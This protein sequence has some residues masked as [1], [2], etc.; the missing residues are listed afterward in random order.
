MNF[1]KLSV[2]KNSVAL[3]C[4]YFP[5]R[6]QAFIW[7][8]W[9]IVSAQRL[10]KIL[11]T[12]EEN[13]LTAAAEMGLNVPPSINEAWLIHGYLTVIRNNWHL[14][15][16]RQLLQLLDWDEV[17]L[18]YTLKEE[19]FL[20][21]KMG[22]DK[23][24]CPPL[25]FKNLSKE[26]KEKTAELKRI[27]L[28][29]F[30]EHSRDYVE[31]PFNFLLNYKTETITVK[32]EQF[33]FNIIHPFS[34]SHGDIFLNSQLDILPDNL[35][36]QYASLGIKGIWLPAILYTLHPIKGAEE[37][38]DGYEI[39][40]KTLADLVKKCAKHGLELYLYLNE[41]RCMPDTFYNKFP[42]WKGVTLDR[43]SATAN[44]TSRNK[45][46]IKWL[47]DACKNIFA[48]TPGLAGAFMITMSEN[49]T[50]CHSKFTGNNCPYCRDRPIPEIITEI[51]CAIKNG[52]H[53]SSPSAKVIVWDWAWMNSPEE[54][55]NID[56]E[57][58]I[59]EKLP[60]DI[61]LMHVSERGLKK[62]ISGVEITVDD[63]SI[64]QV[65]P[66]EKSNILWQHAKKLGMKTVAKVQLNNS[67]ELAAV[68]YIPVP[69]LIREHLEKIS[70][71]KNIDG[72]ILSWT[73]GG[74][75]GGNLE[76]LNQTPEQIALIKFGKKAAP[77]VC[78]AWKIFSE[79]FRNFP[80]DVLLMYLGPVNFGP[81]NILHLE[82]TEHKATM[83]GFPYDD[84]KAW[85]ARFSEDILEEQFRKLSTRWG[86]GLEFLSCAAKYVPKDQIKNII[87][88][89]NISLAAYCHFRSTY[90]QIKFI[91]LR[92]RD[93]IKQKL[94]EVVKEE[95]ELAV[96]LH[97]V[98]RNDSR[99]G[100]EA[101]NHYF[102]SLNDLR[103]K[104][105][106]CEYIL[107]HIN[108]KQR[109]DCVK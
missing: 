86:E 9:E 57:L 90:L 103:E 2:D 67:W 104:V 13:V 56:F 3:D 40:L 52:I 98:M 58:E 54:G 23:P 36:E 72:L 55:D 31:K 91:R 78:E 73:H 53:A 14:L 79:A 44:C 95:L 74:Y 20:W 10:A 7:K 43:I 102:Y 33:K 59:I 85:R 100:F 107:N 15:N 24:V 5:T 81:M 93:L 19:D 47:E 68:P 32:E 99:I 34:A 48:K 96:K 16:Y 70:S 25:K 76:L 38:S 88:Q 50:H 8:N 101:S 42:D 62:H 80:F 41:P 26:E 75:P 11:G 35:L 21:E 17:K 71:M 60:R 46:V 77:I 64:S 92:D 18:A 37:F 69:Y 84:L 22:A 6:Q 89:K 12:T 61:Y 97:D 94:E 28:R 87:E 45:K 106:N 82:N 83:I 51:V 63:Y 109:K 39:R 29:N 65:G 108:Q 49:L 1:K 30:P 27:F 4:P 105:I 66:S